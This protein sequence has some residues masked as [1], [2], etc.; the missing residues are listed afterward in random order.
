[1]VI[2]GFV[3][4]GKTIEKSIGIIVD[5]DET[6]RQVPKG[7][8]AYIKNNTHG[9]TEG[10]YKANSSFPESGGVA[11][12]T[13]FTAVP[14]GLNTILLSYETIPISSVQSGISCNI[15][16]LRIGRIVFVSV[17]TLT[18]SNGLPVGEA[19][20]SGFPTPIG[21]YNSLNSNLSDNTSKEII[22]CYILNG[23][24]YLRKTS[25]DCYGSFMYMTSD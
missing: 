22:P 13:A 18:K 23:N 24:L 21:S 8:Y 16:A 17:A 1:M 20:A 9:L 5:G 3:F 12:S 4:S 25:T 15:V 2:F 11:N 14:A 19:I 6:Y 7:G 10:L